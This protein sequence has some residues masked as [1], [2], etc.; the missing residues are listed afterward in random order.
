MTTSQS[1]FGRAGRVSAAAALL[2][3][4]AALVHGSVPSTGREDRPRADVIRIDGLKQFG[5][6]ERPPVTFLHERHTQAMAKKGKDCAACHLQDK[7]YLSPRYMR[8]QDTSRQ[9]TMDVYHANCIACHRGTADAGEPSGPVVCA[10][11]H[12]DRPVASSWAPIGM[13]KSLHYRHVKSQDNK[14]EV[15]HHQYD[16][17]AK[18]IVYVKGKE[19]DCRF[20]HLDRPVENVRTL[21]AAS[22]AQCI[23]CHRK[24]LAQNQDAGPATCGGCHDAALQRKIA[25]VKDVPRLMRG[26]PDAT[27]VQVVRAGGGPAIDPA[28]RPTVVPFNHKSHETATDTCRACHHAAMDA[29]G[30]CHTLQGSKEGKFVSLQTAMHRATTQASCVGCHDGAQDRKACVG[31]HQSIVR[32]A[33]ADT[34]GCASCHLPTPAGMPPDPKTAAAALLDTRRPVTG[35]YPVDDI[36]ET[37]EIKSLGKQFEPARMPHRKIVQALVKPLAEDRLAGAFHRDPGTVCQACHHNS[38]VSKKPP[39]C[40]S[41][42]GR[43]FDG[44]NLVRPGLQAAYHL[45][46]MECHRVMGIEKPLATDCTGCHKEKI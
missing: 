23:D 15:C 30:K 45:Q 29:C 5:A 17:A 46:C 24:R 31:C 35:T 16:S 42:H 18:K 8:L 44:R 13:D 32:K 19:D 20:C 36:P 37:V 33:G 1:L 28:T 22:H 14:C 25:R 2:L 21:R 27:I 12:Q 7:A 10:G 43:P 11:C 38:P 6:L 41:C 40:A 39:T 3:A 4:A 26:Q 9:A 34:A